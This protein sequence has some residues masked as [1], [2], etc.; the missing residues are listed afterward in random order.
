MG[1][2]KFGGGLYNLGWKMKVLRSFLLNLRMKDAG[3]IISGTG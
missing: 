3:A 1:F 2:V